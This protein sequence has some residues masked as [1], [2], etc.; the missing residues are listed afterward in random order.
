MYFDI[1]IDTV[2][3]VTGTGISYQITLDGMLVPPSEAETRQSSQ[4]HNELDG[5]VVMMPDGRDEIE[6][7][8][9][10]F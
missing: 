2:S 5:D 3:I 4:P 1:K 6:R 10:L 8:V 9:H 7:E